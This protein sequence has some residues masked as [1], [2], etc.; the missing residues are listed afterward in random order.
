MLGATTELIITAEGNR[1]A[2]D[3]VRTLVEAAPT[4]P[5]WEFMHSSLRRVSRSP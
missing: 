3:A 5:G 4:L 1:D 2:F